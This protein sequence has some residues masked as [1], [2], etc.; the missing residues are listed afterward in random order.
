MST[1]FNPRQASLALLERLAEAAV[2]LLYLPQ[3]ESDAPA[4]EWVAGEATY[5]DALEAL[6]EENEEMQKVKT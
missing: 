1:Q 3:S 4:A 6:I 5:N 2:A